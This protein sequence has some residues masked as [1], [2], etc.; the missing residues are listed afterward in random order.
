MDFAVDLETLGRNAGCVIASIGI[1]VFDRCGDKI[2][3]SYYMEP[4]IDPQLRDGF[5]VEADTLSW[6]MTQEDRGVFDY[7]QGKYNLYDCLSNLSNFVNKH[8]DDDSCIWSTGT[9]FDISILKWAY[10]YHNLIWPF[11]YW[12]SRDI[13]TFCDV[14][15]Y[16]RRDFTV[17]GLKAHHALDDAKYAALLVQ[18]VNKHRRVVHEL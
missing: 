11:Q 13:R 12:E 9:D 10:D 17:D 2:D 1:V 4:M 18:D 15:E 7:D 6:W 16:D 8:R 3:D 5:S 14:M